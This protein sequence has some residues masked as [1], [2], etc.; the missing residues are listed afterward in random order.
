MLL[1]GKFRL[2]AWGPW[3]QDQLAPSF[4]RRRCFRCEASEDKLMEVA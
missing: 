2:H 3:V 4:W 1:C